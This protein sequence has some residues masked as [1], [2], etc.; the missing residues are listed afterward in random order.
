MKHKSC[1]AQLYDSRARECQICNESFSCYKSCCDSA[2]YVVKNDNGYI[3]AIL[4]IINEQ[5]TVTTCQ[6]KEGL[7]KRFG[8][9]EL[10]IYYYLSRLKEQGRINVTITG[11]QR[12][13]SLR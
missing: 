2:K 1:F 9:K 5:K 3:V 8:S 11:R 10:N 7:E 4:Q 13:Y 12:M 6:L